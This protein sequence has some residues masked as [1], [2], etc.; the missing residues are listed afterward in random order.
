LAAVL[1][2]LASGADPKT[3]ALL[4]GCPLAIAILTNEEV[5]RARWTPVRKI[6]IRLMLAIAV[7]VLSAIV[8]AQSQRF[9]V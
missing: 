4:L 8:L 3:R 6:I 9:Y 5:S 2:V 7:V 1:I